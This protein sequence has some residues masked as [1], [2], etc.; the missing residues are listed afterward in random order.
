MVAR[1]TSNLAFAFACLLTVAAPA[2]A[3]P[4][5]RNDQF[6]ADRY[7]RAWCG[8]DAQV[9]VRSQAGQVDPLS[10]GFQQFFGAVRIAV[11]IECPQANRI[12]VFAS[13]G[14]EDRLIADARSSNNWT[15][16]ATDETPPSS[17]Q[18]GVP[19]CD[20]LVDLGRWAGLR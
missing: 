14:G 2:T 4:L 1:V 9:I 16:A 10:Q 15:L 13:V 3:A 19:R 20:A 18:G 8:S 7:G 6:V 11:S 17:S 5:A 12:Q